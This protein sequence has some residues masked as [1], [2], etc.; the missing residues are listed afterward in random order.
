MLWIAYAVTRA[1]AAAVRGVRPSN[2]SS[3][4]SSTHGPDV[5]NPARFGP[6]ANRF[7]FRATTR[8]GFL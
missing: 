6:V 5:P 7:N 1:M 3:R 8:R 2:R 4:Q